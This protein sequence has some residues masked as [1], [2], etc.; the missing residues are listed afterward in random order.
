M[1]YKRGNYL[2]SVSLLP[3]PP[4]FVAYH[5]N[6]SFQLCTGM[7]GELYIFRHVTPE[8][9]CSQDPMTLWYTLQHPWGQ[10]NETVGPAF[11]CPSNS[12]RTY[13]VPPP[14]PRMGV[15]HWLWQERLTGVL[16]C[17]LPF[18]TVLLANLHLNWSL[19][20]WVLLLCL[21]HVKKSQKP[22]RKCK[23]PLMALIQ[24]DAPMTIAPLCLWFGFFCQWE[25][26]RPPQ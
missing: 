19:L 24:M 14:V 5:V 8:V 9:C 22:Q 20:L 13:V 10:K 12:C 3:P 23:Y 1:G 21:L 4:Q 11:S 18:F 6:I 2:L 7:A 15:H 17:W 16:P 26:Q 25:T